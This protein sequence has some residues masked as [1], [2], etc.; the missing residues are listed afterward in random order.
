VQTFVR[1]GDDGE[2]NSIIPLFA[3]YQKRIKGFSKTSVISV[4]PATDKFAMND[5]G[6]W[7]VNRH[8]VLPGTEILIEYRHRSPLGGFKEN[9]DYLLLVADPNAPLWQMRIDLPP[10]FLS[11]V[12][13]VFFE[14]R[15]D[16]VSDDSQ[17]DKRGLPLWRKHLGGD[18]SMQVADYMDPSMLPEDQVF[19]YIE[20]ESRVSR[21][22]KV[23]IEETQGGGTRMRIKRTRRIKV[24]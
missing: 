23:E 22:A 3:A 17:L 18:R 14:G 8:E 21:S 4:I 13:A 19:K 15:F 5:A 6:Q 11:N 24:R 10:H 16:L 1:V 12:P 2:G 20:L 7:F 9:I